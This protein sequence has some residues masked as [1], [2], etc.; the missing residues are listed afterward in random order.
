MAHGFLRVHHGEP[1]SKAYGSAQWRPKETVG[2]FAEHIGDNAS[3][4]HCYHPEETAAVLIALDCRE[5]EL[6]ARRVD[7]PARKALVR[8]GR[9]VGAGELMRVHGPRG[10]GSRAGRGKDSVKKKPKRVH[11]EL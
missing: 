7:S 8:W 1:T 9:E 5:P 10:A 3:C 11:H 6:A 4:W 2:W